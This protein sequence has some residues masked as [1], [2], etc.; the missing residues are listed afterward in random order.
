MR[1]AHEAA[2]RGKARAQR[3]A[4][5]ELTAERHAEI[6]GFGDFKD[7]KHTLA[8]DDLSWGGDFFRERIEARGAGNQ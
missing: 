8:G 5:R 2:A 3:T 6:I 4:G 7:G 1:E